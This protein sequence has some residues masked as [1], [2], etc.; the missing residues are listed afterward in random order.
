MPSGMIISCASSS[1]QAWTMSCAS[2]V[3]RAMSTGSLHRC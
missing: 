3:G 1:Q 2:L